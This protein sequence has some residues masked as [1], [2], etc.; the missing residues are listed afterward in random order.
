MG[1]TTA[2]YSRFYLEFNTA[3]TRYAEEE[4]WRP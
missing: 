4:N 3:F 1:T 2:N